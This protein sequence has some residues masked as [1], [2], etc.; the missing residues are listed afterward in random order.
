MH[1]LQPESCVVGGKANFGVNFEQTLNVS[2][3]IWAKF[4]PC[5]GMY[6]VKQKSAGAEEYGIPICG[7][8]PTPSHS[9]L[10]I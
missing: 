10:I 2:A 4:D 5:S 6:L 1:Q 7:R 8:N 3:L 9:L